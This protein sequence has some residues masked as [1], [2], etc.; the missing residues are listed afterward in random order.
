MKFLIIVTSFPGIE[1]SFPGID[2]SAADI[3]L[4]F[5]DIETSQSERLKAMCQ[6]KY[7]NGFKLTVHPDSLSIPYST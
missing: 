6:K 2:F 7:K 1:L 3:D 5:P 4:K